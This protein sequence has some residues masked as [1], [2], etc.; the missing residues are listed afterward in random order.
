M[1]NYY[2][3]IITL[4]ILPVLSAQQLT[5]FDLEIKNGVENVLNNYQK[6]AG[7]TKE[8]SNIDLEYSNSFKALFDKAEIALLYNDIEPDQISGKSLTVI[9]YVST[10]QKN[11]SKGLSVSMD[12]NKSIISEAYPFKKSKTYIVNVELT[13]KVFGLYQQSKILD[14]TEDL[15]FQIIFDTQTGSPANFK[16]HEIQTPENAFDIT[17]AKEEKFAFGLVVKPL[18]TIISSE[19]MNTS[20]GWVTEGQISIN[21]GLNFTY[22]FMP[23]MSIKSGIHYTSYKTNN[24][25]TDYQYRSSELTTDLDNDTYYKDVEASLE[26]MNTLTFIEIP[27]QFKYT[28]KPGSKTS[29]YVFGGV[30]I[31]YL[32]SA[33]YDVSGDASLKG[34]YNE[35]NVLLEDIPEYGFETN[36]YSNT[37]GDWILNQLNFFGNLAFGVSF[38]TG[39]KSSL[40]IG[41]VLNYCLNDLK[42]VEAKYKDDFYNLFGDPGKTSAMSFG[43]SVSFMMF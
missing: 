27:V 40:N 38:K 20:T 3:L 33:D 6:Y 26:E 9:N 12:I 28:I 13:K 24:T 34:Y 7:F 10:A 36:T 35:Y 21:G 4:L 5:G 25:I 2:L 22:Q 32:L 39:Y 19:N 17:K 23:G 37:Q 43:L 18:Y 8:G 1:K 31:S 16:I 42:Y 41:P 29:Y 30:S 14:I 15:V 11:Y